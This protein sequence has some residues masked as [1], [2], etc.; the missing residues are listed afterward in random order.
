MEE[1]FIITDIKRVIM[2]GRDEYLDEV[3]SF[4]HVLY[5]NEIIFHFS[6]ESTVMFDDQTLETTPNTVRFL[7]KG[8][9]SRYDVYRRDFGDCIDIFFQTDRAVSQK[10]FVVD[11]TKNERIGR[12][13]TRLFTTW[14]AKEEGYYHECISL[15]YSIFSELEKRRYFAEKQF[16]KIKPAVD[17]IHN[18]FLHETPTVAELAERSGISESYLK[19]LFIKKYGVPPKKYI[20]QLKVDYACEL[21]KLG[22]YT[23]TQVAELSNFSDVYFFSRQ[24]KAYMGITPTQFIKKYK[25]SK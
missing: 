21:L 9:V 19:A 5:S 3:T 16:L 13:F 4:S 18:S 14:I 20:V 22:R 10:A 7:P 17:V 11:A 2:V 1:K 25:S 23:V 15:L 6:G 24:F 8:R 12:L